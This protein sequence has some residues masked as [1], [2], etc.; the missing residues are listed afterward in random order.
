MTTSLTVLFLVPRH[1]PKPAGD[2]VYGPNL[3]L[4]TINAIV[5]HRQWVCHPALDMVGVSCIDLS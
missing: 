2:F 4:N 1:L 3:P 5:H